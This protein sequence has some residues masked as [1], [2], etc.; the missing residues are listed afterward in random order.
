M[1]RTLLWLAAVAL[2]A[3]GIAYVVVPGAALGIVAID[4][5]PTTEFLLRT[6]GVA[7]VAAGAFLLLVPSTRSWRTRSALLAVAAYLIAG[8]VVDVRAYLDGIVGSAAL[9]SAVVRIAAGALCILAAGV[10]G[11]TG[12][13]RTCRPPGRQRDRGRRRSR[14]RRG[15]TAL[16]VG[17]IVIRVDDLSARPRSGPRPSA[18]T[19]ATSDADDFALLHPKDGVGPN[20]SLDRVRSKVQMPPRIHLDLYA[21]DQAAEVARLIGLGATEIHW[22][23]RPADA[24]YIIMA[25][26]EGNRFCVIDASGH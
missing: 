11:T 13:D 18:T 25:D 12:G 8:S 22:D 14:D 15:M 1:T 5:T 3:V 23:K 16:R 17:S 20:V 19:R 21:E 7:L 9:P 2:V 24:D 6:Q 10:A 26:P 4:A